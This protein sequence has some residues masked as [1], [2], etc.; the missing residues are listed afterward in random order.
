MG[1]PNV[2]L[3]LQTQTFSSFAGSFPFQNSLINIF[4]YRNLSLKRNIYYSWLCILT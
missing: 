1:R 2:S 3:L 4:H